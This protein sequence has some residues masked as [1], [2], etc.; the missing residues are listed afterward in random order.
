MRRVIFMMLL[1]VV[2]SS[3]MAGWVKVITDGNYDNHSPCDKNCFFIYVDI[4]TI[5]KAGDTV[6]VWRVNDFDKSPTSYSRYVPSVNDKPHL[7]V[8]IQEEYNCKEQQVR[9]F[10]ASYHSGH[11]GGGQTVHIESVP[12]K[13]TSIGGMPPDVPVKLLWRAVCERQ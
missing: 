8:K 4:A 3:A 10:F 12:G 9:L 7:S 2:S 6:K 1:S 13:W 11:M 5:S